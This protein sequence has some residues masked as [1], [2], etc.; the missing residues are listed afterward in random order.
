M[1]VLLEPR[2]TD[3][4]IN[5]KHTKAPLR[6]R[7][8]EVRKEFLRFQMEM[9]LLLEPKK[10]PFRATSISLRLEGISNQGYLKKS[11]EKEFGDDLLVS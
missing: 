5:T 4:R 8:T 2:Q 11:F 10:P 1:D 6:S 9:T 7:K 3:P